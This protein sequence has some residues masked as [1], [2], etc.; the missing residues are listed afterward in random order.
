MTVIIAAIFP[1]TMLFPTVCV[2]VCSL[3]IACFTACEAIVDFDDVAEGSL[4]RS[5]GLGVISICALIC[6]YYSHDI[7][8]WLSLDVV[9]ETPHAIQGFVTLIWNF[10]VNFLHHALNGSPMSAEVAK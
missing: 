6:V 10:I 1:A 2:L 4:E 3:E 7:A 8:Q 5:I 9:R